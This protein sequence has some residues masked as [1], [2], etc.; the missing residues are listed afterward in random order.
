MDRTG[1]AQFRPISYFLLRGGLSFTLASLIVFA[2]VAFGERWMY[3]RLGVAGA[4]LVWTLLFVG[5]GGRALRSLAVD[6]TSR[7]PFFLTFAL[8]FMAYAAC[9]ISAYFSLHSPVGEWLGSLTGCIAMALVLAA[10]LRAWGRSISMAAA[11]FLPHSVGYFLGKM[12]HHVIAGKS[13]MLIWGLC[14]GIG[15]GTGLGCALYLSQLK[16]GRP[17]RKDD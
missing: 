6:G 4:Y 5:L 11:L 13:G 8:A 16:A 9:W 15:L 2:T 1:T 3:R 7:L 17:V 14:Y 10:I 12:L